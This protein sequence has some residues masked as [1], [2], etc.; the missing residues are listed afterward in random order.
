M[1]NKK[2]W[3]RVFGYVQPDKPQLRL[4]EYEEYR[5]AYCGLCRSMG[6]HTGM[7]SRFA[8]NYDY[9]FLAMI[10]SAMLGITP[11]IT[12][13]RCVV[14]PVKKRAIVKDDASLEYCAKISAILAYHKVLDNIADCRGAKRLAALIVKPVCATFI[15]ADSRLLPVGEKIADALSRLSSLEKSEES[16]PD[17]LAECFG[18]I[19]SEI[20]AFGLDDQKNTRIA[21]ELGRHVGRYIYFADALDDITDD[22]KHNEFNPFVSAYG[23][24]AVLEHT[25]EIKTALLLELT[26][27]EA[28]LNLVDFSSCPGYGNIVN[29]I[30]YLGM[31]K[32]IDNIIKK[33]CEETKALKKSTVRQ[34]D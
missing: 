30:I 18:K 5:A 10:R 8:L 1:Q 4:W 21:A 22:I 15:P 25:S 14:H 19:M 23:K 24:D 11:D 13:G 32:K 34:K 2:A 26:D 7:L 20:F 33:T 3:C 28:A 9:V 27:L 16:T 17:M 12:S 6:K 31:P 29:N